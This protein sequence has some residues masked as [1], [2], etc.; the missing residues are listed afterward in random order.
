MV[1]RSVH[2][3]AR[4]EVDGMPVSV[5]VLGRGGLRSRVQRPRTRD[6]D[7]PSQGPTPILRSSQ[8]SLS[9]GRA[10]GAGR[11]RTAQRLRGRPAT[12]R[13]STTEAPAADATPASSP[14]SATDGL[15]AGQCKY[16]PPSAPGP[17]C[18]L[19]V[20]DRPATLWA[21]PGAGRAGPGHTPP[22]L[23]SILGTLCF[24]P[25]S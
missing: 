5:L 4:R 1:P 7:T 18:R 17:P 13:A 12:T 22:L 24:R 9:A 15:G 16:E 10:Q 21:S 11:E 25:V 14:P 3:M 2:L 23:V 19:R 20:K 6:S 8:P